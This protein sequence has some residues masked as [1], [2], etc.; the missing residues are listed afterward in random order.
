MLLELGLEALEEREGVGRASGEAGDDR[1]V[2]EP[3]HFPRVG[4]HHRLVQRDLAVA[5]E[6]HF[7][8]AAHTENGGPV[9]MVAI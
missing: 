3:A 2:P 8:V 9:Q 6:R 1:A 4:L 5:A 7:P